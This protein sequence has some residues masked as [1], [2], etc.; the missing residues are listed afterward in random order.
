M[1]PAWANSLQDPISKITRTKWTGDVAQAVEHL[2]CKR[3]PE[4]KPPSHQK[5]KERKQQAENEQKSL[6]K[7]QSQDLESRDLH[8]SVR[9]CHLLPQVTLQ[10]LM[11]ESG[12]IARV[13]L[14]KPGRRECVRNCK[15]SPHGCTRSHLQSAEQ[16]NSIFA[17]FA[18]LENP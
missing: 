5:K 8:S 6:G 18:C 10:L 14:S 3:S 9:E 2:L 4:F 12:A 16:N 7:Q 13:A 15:S 17:A 1:R 11:C